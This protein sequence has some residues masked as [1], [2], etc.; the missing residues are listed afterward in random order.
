MKSFICSLDALMYM[1]GG[2]WKL[3]I[4]WYL[5]DG[6]KRF[7]ELKRL[8]PQITQKM[9]TQQIRELERDSIVIRKVYAQIPPKVEY[10]LTDTGKKLIPILTDLCFWGYEAAEINHMKI[11]M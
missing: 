5:K 9:L 3:F 8:I 4:I 1:I 2:K 7:S 11:E 10:S 6:K